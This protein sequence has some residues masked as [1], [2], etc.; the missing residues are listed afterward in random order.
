MKRKIFY[1]IG[2]VLMAGGLVACAGQDAGDTK[3]I[4]PAVMT[5]KG[6]TGVAMARM[7]DENSRSGDYDFQVVG[8]PDE[9]VAALSSGEAHIAAIPTNLAAKLYSK[10]EGDIVMV[11]VIAYGSLYIL[12]NGD[13]VQTLNDLSGKTVYATGRGANPQYILEYLLNSAGLVPGEDVTIVYKSEH[14]ELAALMAGGEAK[15]AMLP[16]PFVST[17]L[18]KNNAVRVALDFNREWASVSEGELTMSCVAARR[19]FVEAHPEAVAAFL[20]DLDDSITF[21]E[22]D[23][24]S[25]AA[26]CAEYGIIENAAVAE[27]SIPK[28]GLTFITGAAMEPA[29]SDYLRVLFTADPASVGGALPDEAF[30]YIP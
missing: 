21:A 27:A 9:I 5:L 22:G 25:T 6:P 26:L 3:T 29:M 13:S 24:A 28:M 17:V 16:E 12:E 11:A 1:L 7:I 19:D 2:M 15:I 18:A 8:N 30:Y 23:I 14:A 10:T 4:S 20:A